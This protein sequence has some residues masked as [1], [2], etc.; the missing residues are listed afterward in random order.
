MKKVDQARIMNLFDSLIVVEN[1]VWDEIKNGTFSNAFVDYIRSG[2]AKNEKGEL[3]RAYPW[4]LEYAEL[5]ANMNKSKI[6]TTGAAQIGKTLLH[7]LFFS[8]CFSRGLNLGYT[9]AAVAVVPRQVSV[10]LKPTVID[11]IE[12]AGY[13]LKQLSSFSTEFWRFDKHANSAFFLGAT[14]ATTNKTEQGGASQTAKGT[15]V[16]ADMTFSDEISQTPLDFVEQLTS[17]RDASRIPSQPERLIGTP[18]SG[19]GAEFYVEQAAYH[20]ESAV[21]CPFC[22]SIA[23]ISPIGALVQEVDGRWHDR[24]YKPIKWRYR[25]E[26]APIETAYLGCSHCDEELEITE[27]NTFFYDFKN[28]IKLSDYNQRFKKH[29][30]FIA[31][32]LSILLKPKKTARLLLEQWLSSTNKPN[33]FQQ[34][35][36]VPYIASGSGITKEAIVKALETNPDCV[37]EKVRV[38]GIDQGTANIYI[39]CCDFY[40]DYQQ[41]GEETIA[42][43]V[44]DVRTIDAVTLHDIVP[45]V[46]KNNVDLVVCD[47]DPSRYTANL[48]SRSVPCTSILVDQRAETQSD[49]YKLT[50]LKEAGIPYT[51]IA[52]RDSQVKN[53]LTEMFN[54]YRACLPRDFKKYLLGKH[55]INPLLQ[56]Q[57]VT[58]DNQLQQWVRPKDHQD[59]LFMATMFCV[60]GLRYW[61]DHNPR[62]MLWFNSTF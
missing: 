11:A 3:L 42:K 13:S 26:N 36:G 33:F 4:I 58:W 56:L 41:S 18:G 15:S 2:R 14:S 59:D 23:T 34:T 28:N 16:S 40:Y 45:F 53:D 30:D 52:L 1:P 5:I 46:H 49:L 38:L 17:R 31:I 25:D 24:D 60:F 55:P 19:Q 9:F 20:F 44:I 48:I 57:S 54:S 10:Q 7:A 61:L 32:T 35:L 43:T 6:I 47:V 12:L 39:S 51:A 50:K 37:G 62:K 21:H 27:D 29:N 22:K 8:Y